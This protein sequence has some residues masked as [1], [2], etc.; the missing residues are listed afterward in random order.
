MRAQMYVQTLFRKEIF[1]CSH[2]CIK[3]EVCGEM[4]KHYLIRRNVWLALSIWPCAKHARAVLLYR[5]DSNPFQH[6]IIHRCPFF[7]DIATCADDFRN[8]RWFT[9][10]YETYERN[11]N[12]LV[13]WLRESFHRRS[14]WMR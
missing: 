4:Q 7:R 2:V 1:L 5:L 6:A 14:D 8:Q 13:K 3:S 9:R 12:F 11:A 10:T